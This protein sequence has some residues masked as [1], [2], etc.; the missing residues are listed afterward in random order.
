MNDSTLYCE[1]ACYGIMFSSPEYVSEMLY[2]KELRRA[3]F[4]PRKLA[5]RVTRASERPRACAS[6]R[7]LSVAAN[8]CLARRYAR[9]LTTPSLAFSP[10]CLSCNRFRYLQDHDCC[11]ALRNG[12]SST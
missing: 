5:A 2:K 10:S 12:S 4:P 8:N 3:P 7:A 11:N 9:I 6:V 1:V